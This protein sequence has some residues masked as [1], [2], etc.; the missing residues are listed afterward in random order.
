[1]TAMIGALAVPADFAL[2]Y[3]AGTF[4]NAFCYRPVSVTPRVAKHRRVV[5]A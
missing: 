2:I 3:T 5:T 1:M 4:L